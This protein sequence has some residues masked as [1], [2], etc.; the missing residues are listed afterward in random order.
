MY[1]LYYVLPIICLASY[2]FNE[3][4]LTPILVTIVEADTSHIDKDVAL[5]TVKA[6]IYVGSILGYIC[7]AFWVPVIGFKAYAVI[8]TI[9]SIISSLI[10]LIVQNDVR[11]LTVAR[12]FSGLASTSLL[13]QVWLQFLTNGNRY[14]SVKVQTYFNLT[15]YISYIVGMLCSGIASHYYTQDAWK[16]TSIFSQFFFASVLMTTIFFHEPMRTSGIDSIRKL[17]RLPRSLKRMR[18]PSTLYIKTFNSTEHVVHQKRYVETVIVL[19]FCEL[20]NGFSEGLFYVVLTIVLKTLYNFSDLFISI[21]FIFI[22]VVSCVS[23]II[24]VPR[25]SSLFIAQVSTLLSI[26]FV[27]MGLVLKVSD[28]TLILSF[29]L[30]KIIEQI[31]FTQV[32]VVEQG[33]FTGKLYYMAMFMSMYQIGTVLGVISSVYTPS[34]SIYVLAAMYFVNALLFITFRQFL[35]YETTSTGTL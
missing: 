22:A 5:F 10:V 15:Y 30:V 21:T 8:T 4:C 13:S 7:T 23:N 6:S 17:I 35:I 32:R 16:I 14:E 18:L 26:L 11:V 25:V 28:I 9:L 20:T 29:A 24:I 2:T 31:V 1:H 12:F 27:I 33:F 34:G 19:L 3:I